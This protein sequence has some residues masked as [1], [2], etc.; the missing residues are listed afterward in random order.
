MNYTH[1]TQNERYQ[2]Y[3]LRKAGH[4]QREIARLLNRHP[5]T[6]S[7][8]LARNS[9]QRGYRPRQAQHLA[10]ARAANS[11]NAPRIAPAVWL[12]AKARLALQHSPEQI[13]AHLPVSHE[14]LYR[15]IYA[16][17]RAGGELWRNLRCQKQRRKRYASGR[18]LRG[19]IPGRRP[20]AARPPAVESRRRVGHWEGDTL[21]GA[22]QKQAIVSLTERKSGF[23]LLAHVPHKTS[24]AVSQTVIRLLSPFKARVQTLTF[25][26]GLEFAR[27]GE[28]D[29]ALEST[30][31]FADPYASWQRGTNE[32]TNGLVRQYLPKSRPFHTVTEE[33]LAMIMDRLNH[34]P[35]KRLGWKTPHQVFMQSFSRV[36]L[37]G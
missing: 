6:I 21:I 7:R 12:E 26:N 34:R 29:R 13:A 2:I 14:T 36:A 3:V 27:H 20:I 17:K 37:Q 23:C 4:P 11:R 31:Y 33:E 35:R 30:S 22:G 5:S 1:L 28:I 19:Q 24:E 32:N 8:E 10:D 15:R 25:D 9:G 18:S 16:D